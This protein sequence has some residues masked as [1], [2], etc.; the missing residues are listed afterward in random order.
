MTFRYIIGDTETTGLDK[1]KACEVALVEIDENFEIL[2]DAEAL[3][4]PEKE[5]SEIAMGIHGITQEMVASCPT[6]EQWRDQ[7]LQGK[8]EGEIVLIG[9]RIGYDR[10]MLECLFDRIVKAY[11]V[12]PLAQSLYPESVNHKLSTMKEHLTLDGGTAHRAMGDVLT[13]LS[14]LKRASTDTGRSLLQLVNVPFTYIHRMPWG[15]QHKGKLLAEVPADYRA[16]ML[17]LKDLDPNLRKSLELLRTTD[18]IL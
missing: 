10:P 9:Y 1:P 4:N 8:I 5:I 12:L 11:D 2:G 16:W 18:I 6:I 13:T 17:T 7:T 15:K 14:L 3:L